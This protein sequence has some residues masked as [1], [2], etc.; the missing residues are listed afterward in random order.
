MQLNR[1][2][3]EASYTS[4][5]LLS[6]VNGHPCC[7]RW[8]LSLSLVSSSFAT[9][10]KWRPLSCNWFRRFGRPAA[11]SHFSSLWIVSVIRGISGM[12]FFFSFFK[13]KWYDSFKDRFEGKFLRSFYP[14]ILIA[15]VYD[16]KWFKLGGSSLL[17]FRLF[18]VALSTSSLVCQIK[19][20]ERAKEETGKEWK[21][22]KRS[23]VLGKFV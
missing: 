22:D 9:R 19:Y 8:S 17:Q 1:K 23:R 15:R 11:I 7:S 5:R 20:Y 3:I 10:S 12:D 14:V 21:R 2:V 16:N 4:L 6:Q 18:H 13:Q